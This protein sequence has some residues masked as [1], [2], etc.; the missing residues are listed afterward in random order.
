MTF[1]AA[2]IWEHILDFVSAAVVT[3]KQAVDFTNPNLKVATQVLIRADSGIQSLADLKG[4]KS[5]SPRGRQ[6]TFF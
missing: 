2:F 5:L 4:K 6:L 3:V 1:D